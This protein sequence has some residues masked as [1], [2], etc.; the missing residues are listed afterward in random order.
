MANHTDRLSRHKMAV[1]PV[2][3]LLDTQRNTNKTDRCEEKPEGGNTKAPKAETQ[4]Q[5]THFY[6]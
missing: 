1:L 2:K 5:E 4:M 6:S 3:G